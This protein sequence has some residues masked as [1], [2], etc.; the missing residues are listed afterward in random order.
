M[1]STD[2][3]STMNPELK[4]RIGA[5]LGRMASGVYVVTMEDNQGKEGFLATWVTQAAFSPPLLTVAVNMQRPFL[6]RLTIGTK[7]T[8]NVLSKQSTDIFKNFAKPYQEGFD[9]FDGLEL[10]KDLDGPPAFANCI[11]CMIGK[12]AHIAEA[13]DHRLVVCEVID[14]V[15][16]NKDQEPMVHFRRDGFQ[17]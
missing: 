11:A 3:L 5:C 16:L 9:R 6:S 13:G 14:G 1:T 8:F 2:A 12:V 15:M 10:V 4:Q 7:C 17:Y